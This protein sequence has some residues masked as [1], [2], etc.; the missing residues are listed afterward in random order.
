VQ[1]KQADVIDLATKLEPG[2]QLTEEI[3][4][5]NAVD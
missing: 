5:S 2:A 1:L 4:S 3:A